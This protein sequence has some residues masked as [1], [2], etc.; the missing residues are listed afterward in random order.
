MKSY[1]H[2][3]LIMAGLAFL[4]GCASSDVTFVNIT[5]F[6][7]NDH[8]VAQQRLLAPNYAKIAT[9]DP[10]HLLTPLTKG[11]VKEIG[12]LIGRIVG[13]RSYHV[14]SLARSIDDPRVVVAKLFE[15]E[16]FLAK[17]IH[18]RIVSVTIQRPRLSDSFD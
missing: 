14:Y 7:S 5:T 6:S 11:D 16:V 1:I 3:T 8:K 2:A 10:G 18:W 17:G 12:I 4:V 15:T 9:F 13:L